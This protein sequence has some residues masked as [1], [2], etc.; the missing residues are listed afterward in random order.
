MSRRGGRAAIAL[1][2]YV[3]YEFTTSG[4]VKTSDRNRW[5]YRL[6][7]GFLQW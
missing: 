4:V 7:T 5:G 3:G 2:P 1:A 6:W